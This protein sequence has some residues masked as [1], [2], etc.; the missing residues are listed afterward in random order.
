MGLSRGAVV[1]LASAWE[2]R[3][4]M[5]QP[6]CLVP[7]PLQ[8]R[9]RP[10]GDGSFEAF[11][12]PPFYS[13]HAVSVL[14]LPG[15]CEC[16][17][18]RVWCR[19]H[20]LGAELQLLLMQQQ[21]GSHAHAPS[22]DRAL[23]SDHALAYALVSAHRHALAHTHTNALAHAPCVPRPAFSPFGLH[24]WQASIEVLPSGAL[25][26]AWFSGAEEEANDCAIVLATL[27]PNGTQ[28]T[29]ARCVVVVALHWCIGTAHSFCCWPRPPPRS[30]VL[31]MQ[32]GFSDQNPVVF[33][34]A[35][36][37]VLNVGSC[38]GGGWGGVGWGG[39]WGEGWGGV[40][41]GDCELRERGQGGKALPLFPPGVP[42]P[43]TCHVR[44][45]GLPDLAGY[46]P[47]TLRLLRP[48]GGAGHTPTHRAHT[49]THS[50]QH[51][52]TAL[53]SPLP[54]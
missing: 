30:R 44:R 47:A 21:S 24:Y 37:A 10:A 40:G 4:L 43:R 31:S 6:Q 28:W 35:T 29:A 19:G 50:P 39:E 42:L 15:E 2:R 49:H 33:Y 25:A 23:A 41:V 36:T 12:I 7:G 22:P 26:L 32:N 17:C 3:V 27:P 1:P 8:L 14:M 5:R 51:N 11:M 46:V 38:R 53:T 13:N 9:V 34:D 45:G 16:E 20:R 48:S 18:V 52:T 54:P